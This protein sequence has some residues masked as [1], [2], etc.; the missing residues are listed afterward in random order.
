MTN[1]IEPKGKAGNIPVY[2]AFDEIADIGKMVEHPRNPNTHPEAQLELLANI[3]QNQGWRSPIT[4]SKRS[5][6][7]IKGHGRLAAAKLIKAKQVPVD[8][9]EYKDE[10]SEW[11]DLI[12]DNRLSELAEMDRGMLADIMKD[13]QGLD[14]DIELTGYTEDEL[15]KLLADEIGDELGEDASVDDEPKDFPALAKPGDIWNVG[16]HRIICGDSTDEATIDRLMQDD[17]AQ[18]VNTDPPYG[19]SYTGGNNNKSKNWDMLENDNLVEDN[20]VNTLLAPAFRHAVKH[21]KPNASFYIWH[22][23]S[24]KADF[25]AA[26]LK[27]GLIE[28]QTIMW[29]KNHFTFG[30]CDYQWQHEEC[31][32]AEKAGEKAEWFGGRDQTTAW[33]VTHRSGGESTAVLTGGLKI[34]DGDGGM[35]FVQEKAP[36]GKKVRFMRLKP[37]ESV[38][39]VENS[40]TSTAW[41][42]T[43][44]AN[45]KHP[46]QKPVELAQRAINNSSNIGDIV[47]DLFAGS[48]STMIACE[49]TNREARMCELDPRYVDLGIQRYIDV[50]GKTDITVERDGKTIAY[51]EVAKVEKE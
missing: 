38:H 15:Q 2:C 24:T 28:K 32:Y 6:F 35:I 31:F 29:I 42:V 37:G 14:I 39:L 49:L 3:I 50:T 18:L 34:A 45:I 11:A 36:K 26:M 13:V 7:I 12:A 8:Y 25:A 9:Q 27:A 30:R 41:E 21:T 20:L 44:D 19:V 22:S 5:G 16:C 47:L 43:K 46:T 17:K 40:Q 4:V 23:G 33:K 51:D 10:A 48:H 1:E